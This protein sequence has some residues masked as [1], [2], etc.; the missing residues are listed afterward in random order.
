MSAGHR[1]VVA[2][3]LDT[4][5]SSASAVLTAPAGAGKTAVLN[6]VAF[7]CASRSWR[8]VRVA[9]SASEP[10]GM[11]GFAAQLACQPGTGGLAD[12]HVGQA[13]EALTTAEAARTPT[14]LV[15]DGAE[16]LLPDTLRV[17]QLACEMQPLLQVFFAGRPKFGDR[18]A[19]PELA[20]LRG[21]FAPPFALPPLS[22][23]EA[24]VLIVHRM[25]AAGLDSRTPAGSAILQTLISHGAGNPGRIGAI[26][27]RAL[28]DRQRHSAVP[29]PTRPGDERGNTGGGTVQAGLAQPTPRPADQAAA[30]PVRSARRRSGIAVPAA[31]AAALLGVIG[32]GA[33]AFR[34][35]L[36]SHPLSLAPV[37]DHPMPGQLASPPYAP[38]SLAVVPDQAAATPTGT[39]PPASDAGLDG[40]GAAPVLPEERATVV[41]MPGAARSAPAAATATG[42]AEPSATIGSPAP[43]PGSGGAT[44]LANA[45]KPLAG[46]VPPFSDPGR[47]GRL[48]ALS[49]GAM[50]DRRCRDILR[51]MQLGEDATDAEKG[52][53]R[54]G[55]RR[56]R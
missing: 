24:A 27:D 30:T 35:S 4:L 23:R 28:A 42:D 49:T 48:T 10:L 40:N 32:L 37:E 44:R 12:D 36:S 46:A 43:L 33:V 53:L 54:T 50:D 15:V 11:R 56:D 45:A 25:R 55:C 39:T 14:L 8:L 29:L 26:L 34:T 18:L 3:I 47:S 21:R 20:R 7:T 2:R 16:T 19:H 1:D 52:F 41:V 13:L 5:G 9:G 31:A 51:R 17:I 6:A 38:Q 22:E